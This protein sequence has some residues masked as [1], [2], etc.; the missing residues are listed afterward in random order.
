MQELRSSRRAK[1]LPEWSAR[2]RDDG[3]PRERPEADVTLED[4]P[5]ARSDALFSGIAALI[6]FEFV[7]QNESRVLRPYGVVCPFLRLGRC[8][9][10]H[11]PADLRDFR[12]GILSRE[13]EIASSPPFFFP[14]K[15]DA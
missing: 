4:L 2:P 14:S 10:C 5:V 13:E 8:K 11:D 1:R 6:S 15:K 7:A 12:S 9:F 3:P